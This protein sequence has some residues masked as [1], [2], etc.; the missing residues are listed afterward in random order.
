MQVTGGCKQLLVER[1]QVAVP[2]SLCVILIVLPCWQLAT[3]HPYALLGCHEAVV[4][5]HALLRAGAACCDTSALSRTCRPW[6]AG[7]VSQSFLLHCC[8]IIE[9]SNHHC[10]ASATWRKCRS[11]SDVAFCHAA[12]KCSAIWAMDRVLCNLAQRLC[13]AGDARGGFRFSHSHHGVAS[14]EFRFRHGEPVNLRREQ[15][16]IMQLGLGREARREAQVHARYV[17]GAL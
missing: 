17:L 10:V 7:G 4:C 15:A 14:V 12:L 1:R 13:S 6:A 11:D 2:F 16:P 3:C 5:F 8:S 9:S